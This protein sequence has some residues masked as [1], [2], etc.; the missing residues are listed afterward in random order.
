MTTETTSP[1]LNERLRDLYYQLDAKINYATGMLAEHPC[2]LNAWKVIDEINT[3]RFE[4][5]KVFSDMESE[6]DDE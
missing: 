6:P 2:R 3:I 5:D 4:I 1:T